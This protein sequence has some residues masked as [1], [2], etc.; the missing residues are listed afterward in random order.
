MSW[1]AHGKGQP[2]RHPLG[3]I[4]E[5]DGQYQHGS[6]LEPGGQAFRRFAVQM[7][8]GQQAVQHHEHR[9]AQHESASYWENGTLSGLPGHVHSWDE[10]GPH[11]R[12]CH[13][14][15]GKAQEN[16]LCIG[17][18]VLSKEKDHGRSHYSGQAGEAGA[19]QSIKQFTQQHGK[20]PFYY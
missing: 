11:C 18:H 12:G 10:Q 5:G 3:D 15:G 7:E 1:A 20:T 2:Y 14:S 13:D 4:V 9:R 17:G 19:Q 8:V 6:P 16:F